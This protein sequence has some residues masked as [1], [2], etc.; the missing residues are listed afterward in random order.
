MNN[1]MKHHSLRRILIFLLILG[2]AIDLKA[3]YITVNV[4]GINYEL[5]YTIYNP[6]SI[7]GG[8]PL[9]GASYAVVDSAVVGW[10]YDYNGFA[11][12]ASSVTSEV[13]VT[14]DE[15]YPPEPGET[16]GWHMKYNTYTWNLSAPVTAIGVRFSWEDGHNVG[17]GFR[18]SGL[19]GVSIPNTVK[20]IYACSFDN[21][22][23]L[24]SVTIP[25]SV[26]ILGTYYNGGAFQGCTSLTDVTIGNSVK[27]IGAN[28]FYNC[29][30]LMNVDIPNTVKIIDQY[31][32]AGS[33]LTSVTI[34]NSVTTIGKKA[35]CECRNLRS[36]TLGNSIEEI[37]AY[38]FYNTNINRIYVNDLEAY[39]RIKY[40]DEAANP[41]FIG[42]RLFL[43]NQEITNLTI[44][45]TITSINDYAFSGFS[46]MSSLA[47]PKSVTSIGRGA[48]S[49]GTGLTSA[50][51]GDTISDDGEAMIIGPYAFIGCSSLKDLTIGNSVS[52]IGSQAFSQCSNLSSLTLPNSIKEIG[53]Y[54][55]SACSNLMNINM[56]QSVTSIGEAAFSG[57][58]NLK[59]VDIKDLGAWCRI[60]FG[61]F[62]SNPCEYSKKLY[63][64]GEEIIDLIIPN[65]VTTI[66]SL[67]FYFCKGLKSVKISN[68]VLD[69]EAYAF[70]YCSGLTDLTLG[71]SV[72]YIRQKAFSGCNALSSI[73]SKSEIAPS[74]DYTNC[75]S[76]SAYNNATVYVPVGSKRDYELTN[77]WNLFSN[78]VE[79]NMDETPPGDTNGDG[80]VNV[81][82][83]NAV[84]NVILN[85]EF[86]S[87]YDV[88][89]DGEINIADINSIINIILNQ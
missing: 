1:K 80:E 83:V 77:Y 47:I 7:N 29:P 54:A 50:L 72:A 6:N 41:L 20:Y 75:F 14:L 60:S 22:T 26:T 2:A 40:G 76:N 35:F 42:H 45:N 37:E 59:R 67:A 25:N 11:E 15:Y 21:C 13:T 78:I 74:M 84:I 87:A 69:I 73:Y 18:S 62:S 9:Y 52:I 19:T 89:D 10:N 27:I 5:Y 56:P 8:L 43:N 4:N 34:P 32:F 33:G 12:I 81:A 48:F 46:G 55:F 23:N 58:N 70:G 86:S 64:N 61:G 49:Y 17:G 36:V 28:A 71:N 38:A 31:A 85:G 79:M 44:P 30:S 39:C 68:S 66:N 82:D 65:T 16:G 51:I 63:L 53:G 24:K 57:C 88:N 3:N